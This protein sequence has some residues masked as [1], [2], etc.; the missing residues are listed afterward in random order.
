M[1]ESSFAQVESAKTKALWSRRLVI[2]ASL[3][4]GVVTLSA[5]GCCV[6]GYFL[7]GWFNPN[8]SDFSSEDWFRIERVDVK[9]ILPPG[10]ELPADARVV[11]YARHGPYHS[12][13]GHY[14]WLIATMSRS[15]AFSFARGW[16]NRSCRDLPGFDEWQNGPGGSAI[17]WSD[18]TGPGPTVSS[19][20]WMFY[21]NGTLTF[22][23]MEH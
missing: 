9:R 16:P 20:T 14:E 15:D 18:Q 4:G 8:T 13:P 17:C 11:A 1:Q 22:N 23:S 3:M 5:S 2:V 19:A 21:E 6:S 10:M 7:L 12:N